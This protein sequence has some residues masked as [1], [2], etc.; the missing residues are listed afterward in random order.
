MLTAYPLPA[1]PTCRRRPGPES[2]GGAAPVL[3]ADD[4]AERDG[5]MSPEEVISAL[6]LAALRLTPYEEDEALESEPDVDAAM[7]AMEVYRPVLRRS[8]REG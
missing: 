5:P 3:V 4:H 1:G 6:G 2:S 8:L 7:D